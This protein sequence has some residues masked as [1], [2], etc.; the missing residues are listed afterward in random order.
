[1]LNQIALKRLN[2]IAYNGKINKK[3]LLG[4]TI[5]AEIGQLGFRIKN[6]QEIDNISSESLNIIMHTLKEMRGANVNYVPLFSKF[7]DEI[8]N[9]WFYLIK[10]LFSFFNLYE[11]SEA[12]KEK[13][14]A[15]P[16]TQ[17]QSLELYEEALAKQKEKIGD[18][19]IEWIELTALPIELVKLRLV[20]WVLALIYGQTPIQETLWDDILYCLN[21]LSIPFDCNKVTIKETLV[22]LVAKSWKKANS[23]QGI[24]TPTDLIRLF[25]YLTAQD[26][27]L[28][29]DIF[30]KGLKYSKPQRREIIQFLENCSN[31]EEDLLRYQG[32]WKKILK[33]LHPGDYKDKF[34]KVVKAYD[35][36]ING[37]ILSFEGKLEKAQGNAKLALLKQRPS[38]LIRKL[39]NLIGVVSTDS[40]VSTLQELNAED[41]PL[42]LLMQAFFALNYKGKR[43]IINKQGKFYNVLETTLYLQALDNSKSPPLLP[44]N[45]ALDNLIIQK[46]ANLWDLNTKVWIDLRL[47]SYILP[48]QAR[49]QSEG[50]LNLARGTRIKLGNQ[51]V[52]RS[53]VYWKQQEKRTDYDLALMKLDDNF[54]YAGRV[55]WSSY[56]SEGDIIFSGDI[57]SAELGACEFLDIKLDAVKQ[58]NPYLVVSVLVFAGENFEQVTACYSGWM[59]RDN[60][61][62]DVATF[63]AK[64]VANKVTVKSTSQARFWV[65]FIIDTRKGELIYVDLYSKGS[66]VIEGNKHLPATVAALV[67]YNQYRPNFGALAHWFKRANKAQL[68]PREKAEITIGMDDDCTINV[69]QL[70]GERIFTL[71]LTK[72]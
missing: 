6:Y 43:L 28:A 39:S 37:E 3:S 51:K 34:P 5:N 1:M 40:L 31:L 67:K 57:Q 68:T 60:P 32:L 21:E 49:K 62:N 69:T 59:M 22:R 9:Q 42:P 10:R 35:R 7:P 53:F 41:L 50:L 29:E 13:F 30:L 47:F 11:F 63:D 36:L 70:V 38:M 27:S 52:L 66:N 56:S 25:A 48:L 72:D 4:A 17:Y 8:P 24:K 33:G 71:G 64:T 19:H 14:G 16:T 55:S 44:I 15:D 23:L 26:V 54:N 20:E 61:E 65:P 58:T 46:L 2:L 45:K 18:T 12:E